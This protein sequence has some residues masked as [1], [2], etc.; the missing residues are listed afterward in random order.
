[1]VPERNPRTLWACQSVAFIR[2]LSVAPSGRFSRSRI[3]AALLPSRAAPA[4][5]W[6]LGAFFCGVAFFPALPFL[7]ATCARRAPTRAFLVPFGF[8]VVAGVVPVSS[9]IDVIWILLFAVI[10][11]VMT[12]IALLG[13]E[14]KIIRRV[15][16]AMDWR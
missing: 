10:T 1:M 8:A 5:L 12:W 16:E 13:R 14:S 6:P 2:P 15:A 4:F 7:G 3:L 11:A 9:V